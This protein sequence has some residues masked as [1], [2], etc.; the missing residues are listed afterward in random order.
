MTFNKMLEQVSKVKKNGCSKI[1][2]PTTTQ[3]SKRI[4]TSPLTSLAFSEK[5]KLFQR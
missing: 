3:A 2:L 4:I 5:H 1:Y